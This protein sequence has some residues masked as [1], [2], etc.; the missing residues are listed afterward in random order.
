MVRRSF[1]K[2][3]D[4]LKAVIAYGGPEVGVNKILDA[5]WP[6]SEGDQA[7]SSFSTTLNRLRT[8]LDFKEAIRLR[9]GVLMIDEG[10]CRID[11]RVFLDLAARA[12]QL[13][14]RGEKER[15]SVACE[16]AIDCYS[17]NFLEEESE[18]VWVL[19]Y[20]ERLRDLFIK[21]ITRLGAFLEEEHDFEKALSLYYRGLIMDRTNEALYRRSMICYS[22]LGRRA[23]VEKIYRKCSDTLVKTLNV[24]PSQKTAD[25]YKKAL[26]T[27]Q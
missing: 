2:P 5:F 22:S 24:N 17:G 13:W 14:E 25:V 27:A 3:L 4:L 9:D 18:I 7:Y 19:S 23:E 16:K 21:A 6:D 1:K 26:R 8:L 12:D 15:A 11:A 10:I 20:R